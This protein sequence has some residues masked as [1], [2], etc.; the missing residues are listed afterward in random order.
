[1]GAAE[2]EGSESRV[3]RQCQALSIS[4]EPTRGPEETQ[5]LTPQV[6]EAPSTAG[7][8]ASGPGKSHTPSLATERPG[9]SA[10]DVSGSGA[11]TAPPTVGTQ[12]PR[13]L[14]TEEPAFVATE[15]PPS[16]NSEVPIVLAT[17]TLLVLEDGP[18]PLPRSTR[19]SVL[20]AAE[21]VVSKTSAPPTR[22]EGSEHPTGEPLTRALEEVEAEA[23]L[24]PSS[25]FLASV[26]PAP[27]QAEGE[28]ESPP[29]SEVLASIL[30]AQAKLGEQ[31]ATLVHLG[32]AKSLPSFPSDSAS[33]NAMGGRTLALK[34][35]LPGKARGMLPALLGP[36]SA[37]CPRRGYAG[38]ACACHL[39]HGCGWG[40]RHRCLQ[41]EAKP[42]L[43][44][45][46]CRGP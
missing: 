22:P 34:S 9:F 28:A 35:S 4:S 2:G 41:A 33:G 32:H 31:Q 38:G 5:D 39:L 45:H 3:Q 17:P 6:T 36:L 11:T 44:S 46:R 37:S 18:G 1:M 21:E 19:A 30:P 7:D 42:L 15:A 40:I 14:A 27:S 24:P 23:E 8:E 25:E 13:P 29:P 26:L 10:P 20:R 43:P 12:A 16:L